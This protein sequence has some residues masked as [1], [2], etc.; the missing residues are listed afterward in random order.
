MVID[1]WDDVGDIMNTV[2]S[3]LFQQYTFIPDILCR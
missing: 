2:W 1:A 3:Q